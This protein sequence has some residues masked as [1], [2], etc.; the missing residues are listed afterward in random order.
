MDPHR[1]LQKVKTHKFMRKMLNGGKVIAY[2]GKTLPAEAGIL[3][4][5]Y[6]KGWVVVGDSASMVDVQS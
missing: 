3:P 2:G 6:G 5:L 4:K 1:E